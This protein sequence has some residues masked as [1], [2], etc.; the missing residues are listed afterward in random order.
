MSSPVPADSAASRNVLI[1]PPP[2]V[3]L[4]GWLLPGL[5]YW[6][7]GQRARGTTIGVTVISMFLFGMLVGGVRT[8]DAAMIE[9]VDQRTARESDDRERAAEVES[10]NRRATSEA[11]KKPAYRPP[12]LLVRTLQKPWFIG[13]VMAGPMAIGS[14]YVGATWGGNAGAPYSHAR[15]YEIGV[16]YT[17]VAG[18]LNLMAVIDSAYRASSEGGGR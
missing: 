16:L 4:A 1:A 2:I 14:A 18:M 5:G 12:N 7:I 9:S 11:E 17:A 13:Q 15:V 3:A 10:A 6:L 8:V